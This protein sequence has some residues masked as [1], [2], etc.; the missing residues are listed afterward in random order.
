MP[1]ISSLLQK[2]YKREG[3]RII[4]INGMTLNQLALAMWEKLGYSQID[5]SVISRVI[6]GERD[7]TYKQLLVFCDL[8]DLASEERIYLK[9][10][11]N[12]SILQRHNID[13][14]FDKL[15]KAF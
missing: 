10:A 2:Y 6:K 4:F 14:N 11:L 15:S 8:L 1:N 13:F 9:N 5:A 7:F 3:N 12:Q